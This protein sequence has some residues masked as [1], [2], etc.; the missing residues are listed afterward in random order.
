M[1]NALKKAC[2]QA[3]NAKVKSAKITEVQ[4]ETKETHDEEVKKLREERVEKIVPQNSSA[5]EGQKT[6]AREHGKAVSQAT[7]STAER[8]C[9]NARYDE[10]SAAQQRILKAQQDKMDRPANTLVTFCELFGQGREVAESTHPAKLERL[11]AKIASL[12][13]DL[14]MNEIQLQT[15][16][17][18]VEEAVRLREEV[19]KVC[20]EASGFDA[21]L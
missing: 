1:G 5:L 8:D 20:T 14:Q 18:L 17:Q 10:M 19:G 4:E 13:S 12:I 6:F 9:A 11:K 16:L 3:D 7:L 2:E 15:F 21:P